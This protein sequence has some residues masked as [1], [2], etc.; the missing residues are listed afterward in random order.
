ML[1]N[2]N[3]SPSPLTLSIVSSLALPKRL[4]IGR[5]DSLPLFDVL[6]EAALQFVFDD[7]EPSLC[8]NV[9]DFSHGR[10]FTS[11]SASGSFFSACARRRAN[12]LAISSIM[13]AIPV[14]LRPIV[15]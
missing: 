6:F 10:C 14:E 3:D 9:L 5:G 1:D 11:G 15:P 2:A 13:E 4:R 8:G 7:E 12:V